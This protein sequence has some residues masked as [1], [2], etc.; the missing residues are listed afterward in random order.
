MPLLDIVTLPD[1]I[2]RQVSEPL[3]GLDE[4]HQKLIDAM[5]ETMY[6]A[7]GIGLAGIQ[8]AFPHRLIVMDCGDPEDEARRAAEIEAWHQAVAEAEA[9][10]EAPPERPERQ[11]SKKVPYALINPR[12]VAASDASS[13]YEEGC[14]SIPDYFAHVER[15]ASVTVEYL[16]RE[17]KPQ[18]MAASGLMATCVQHEID[19]LDGKL[20]IDHISALKRNMVV[21]KFTK[22]ARQAGR[23]NV[24]PLVL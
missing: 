1:P 10:G 24:P 19:H 18:V 11:P 20:F 4:R 21:K 3:Q 14:L 12:I 15:P 2:L 5:F 6:E 17:G 7:P 22:I 13:L 23:G 8:V 16:D 9:R